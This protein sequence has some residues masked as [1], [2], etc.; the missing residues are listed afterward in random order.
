MFKSKFLRA[1]RTSTS[2]ILMPQILTSTPTTYLHQSSFYI[3]YTSPV[4]ILL[5][6]TRLGLWILTG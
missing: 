2:N 6:Q 5:Q 3:S 4:S 1:G